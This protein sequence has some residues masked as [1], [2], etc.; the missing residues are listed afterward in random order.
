MIHISFQK[1]NLGERRQFNARLY[2]LAKAYN[3]LLHSK[4]FK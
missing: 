3:H 2:R 1:G 4:T